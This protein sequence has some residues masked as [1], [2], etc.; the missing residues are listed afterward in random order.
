MARS[1]SLLERLGGA[2]EAEA[3]EK[4]K[5]EEEE[6]AKKATPVYHSRSQASMDL[7]HPME[8]S[9]FAGRHT[10]VANTENRMQNLR[11]AIHRRIVD[12]M[13]PQEQALV[14]LGEPARDQIRTVISSYADRELSENPTASLT[15]AERF[16]LVDDICDELLGLGPLEPLLKDEA[17]TEI[18][19]NGPQDIFVE[20]RGK[21]ML[22]DTHFHD[23]AHLMS[24]IERILTPLG[25]RV[26]ESSPLVDAR[27]KDGS[28]ARRLR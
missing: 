7:D 20:Q 15:R 12:E 11:M 19:I 28:R 21:L 1:L 13:T 3:E 16:Q 25:R 24:I 9:A 23:E 22:T 17:I 26:D 5:K 4:K 27:L 10:A 8:A 18:M 6:K 2:K 14:A